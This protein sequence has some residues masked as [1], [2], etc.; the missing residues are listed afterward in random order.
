MPMLTSPNLNH[1]KQHSALQFVFAFVS[2]A[3]SAGLVYGWPALRRNLLQDKNE[4]ILSEEILGAIFTVGSWATLGGSFLTGLCRDRFGTKVSTA[5]PILSVTIG[6][7]GIAF[8]EADNALLLGVS[9]FLI[10]LGSGVQIGL[11]PVAGLFESCHR[12]TIL[13]TFS[14]AFQVS[15]LMFLCLLDLISDDRKKSVGSFCVFLLF[16]FV[17]SLVI[18]PSEHYEKTNP[19]KAQHGVI[20]GRSNER[21]QQ[22]IETDPTIPE[23]EYD[24]ENVVER[25]TG[26]V[27]DDT[28]NS[29]GERC[30]QDD[31][32]DACVQRTDSLWSFITSREYILLLCWFSGHVIPLQYYIATIGLHLEDRGDD[33]GFYTSIFSILFA[34]SALFAPFAGKLADFAGLGRAQGLATM[35]IS[36]SLLMIS[37]ETIS[38]NVHI[39]GIA[40]YSLGRMM[41]FGMYFSNIGKRLGFTHYGT[42]AGVGLFVSAILSLIQYP[43]IKLAAEGNEKFVDVAS[44]IFVLL[45]GIPYCIWLHRRERE[46]A[47]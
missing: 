12:G 7:T 18:T 14:G 41:V 8:A 3:S 15:G 32:S 29:I 47:S 34:S 21:G 10:G 13:A 4:N 20:E 22:F 2:I 26:G 30:Q 9:L 46:D 6:C 17:V 1:L 33:N 36:L 39:L 42:L 24:A 19:A 35:L 27:T 11:H 37:L 38:L 43:L 45:Q 16:L 31:V 40:S 44:S 25:S 28:C 23:I 5:V